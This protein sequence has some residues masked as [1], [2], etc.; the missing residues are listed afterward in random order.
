M[1]TFLTIG[2]PHYKTHN[3]VETDLFE[4]QLFEM[5]KS[6][7]LNIDFIVVL[8]DVL[9]RHENIHINPLN[10][11][12]KLLTKLA[13]LA[14]TYVLIGNHDRP[15]NNDFLSDFSPFIG[16]K[17]QT[18]L[19]I[20][21]KVYHQQIK[22]TN[23]IFVPYVPTGRFREALGTINFDFQQADLI[24][25]H[26]EFRGAKTST[27]I[28]EHGDTWPEIFPHII[29]GHFHD[30]HRLQKNILYTGTPFQHS[31]GENDDKSISLFNYENSELIEER[32][33]L[34]MPKKKTYKYSVDEFKALKVDDITSDMKIIITGKAYE[35]EGLKTIKLYKDLSARGVRIEIRRQETEI[36][37][38]DTEQ[39]MDFMN[40][41]MTKIQDKPYLIEI[42]NNLLSS[43]NGIK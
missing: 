33:Y 34:K 24:F 40:F 13:E 8:G 36:Q 41:L 32:I 31:F 43:E 10:R 9:D 25:A 1:L 2:D 16:L 22:D 4:Q 21:D 7:K 6:D 35:L 17:G 23:L 14:P 19:F 27:H 29:S 15:N 3:F 5:F 42:L 26:Q 30:H 11:A 38:H 20:I 39:I 37:Y 12:V 18:N 28:S